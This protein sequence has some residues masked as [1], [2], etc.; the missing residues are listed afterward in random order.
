MSVSLSPPETVAELLERLGGIPLDRIRMQPPP[1][2]ATAED[3]ERLREGDPKI[4]CEL[5]DGVLV[6]SK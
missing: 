2:T 4:L 5:I 6:A 3:A 1:G